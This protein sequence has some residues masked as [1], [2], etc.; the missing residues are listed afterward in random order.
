MGII[1]YHG[2]S[3]LFDK[4]DQGKARVTNDFYGGGVAYFTS[5]KVVAKQY[6]INMA[7]VNKSETKVIY[8]VDL[9]YKKLFDVDTVYTG[10][11]L[12]QF[13]NPNSQSELEN[14]AR[15]ANLLRLGSDKFDIISQLKIGTITLYGEDV[16]K[17]ISGGMIS[18]ARARDKL[19]SLGY[20]ALRYNGGQNMNMAV[21]H[22][23]YL[24]YNANSIR[25]LRKIFLIKKEPQN[26]VSKNI[27][28]SL[29][30]V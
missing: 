22:D 4:F 7:K 26:E 24:A 15:A 29:E 3:N 8:E 13:F 28:V 23:V 21:K 6:A 2:T 30:E 25:I 16:F 18:T 10:K 9:N 5:D 17:G 12:H 11:Q 14:F 19:K 1:V 27:Q 20:D